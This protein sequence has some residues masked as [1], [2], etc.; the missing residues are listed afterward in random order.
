MDLRY[1][2]TLCCLLLSPIMVLASSLTLAFAETDIQLKCSQNPKLCAETFQKARY[3]CQVYMA[4]N[5]GNTTYYRECFCYELTLSNSCSRSSNCN[6][7][8]NTG[9]ER[10]NTTWAAFQGGNS[11]HP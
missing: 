1:I 11:Q 7:T 3:N 6:D 2:F 10:L 4:G 8:S 9:Y 5:K